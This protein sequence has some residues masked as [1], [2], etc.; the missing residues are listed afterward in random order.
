MQTKQF[1]KK[2]NKVIQGRALITGVLSVQDRSLSEKLS[3]GHW[4]G[5]G[6]RLRHAADCSDNRFNQQLINYYNEHSEPFQEH[7]N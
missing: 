2:D 6:V 4:A 3:T 7:K 1:T 5:P